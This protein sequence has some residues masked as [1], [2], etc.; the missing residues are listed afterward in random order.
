MPLKCMFI[1]KDTIRVTKIH[2]YNVTLF[3]SLVFYMILLCNKM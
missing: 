2:F 3:Y 1:L